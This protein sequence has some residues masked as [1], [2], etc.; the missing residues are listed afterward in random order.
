MRNLPTF[1]VYV[2]SYKNP[3]FCQKQRPKISI[4]EKVMSNVETPMCTDV[5]TLYITIPGYYNYIQPIPG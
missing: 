4:Q 5:R 1:V 2:I 3:S